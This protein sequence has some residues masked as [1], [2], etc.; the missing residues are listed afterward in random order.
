MGTSIFFGESVIA[1]FGAG[2]IAL[3]AP[4]AFRSCCRRISTVP[5]RTVASWWR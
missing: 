4:C 5:S 3:F 1:A 2:V